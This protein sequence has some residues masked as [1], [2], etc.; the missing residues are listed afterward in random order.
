M[1]FFVHILMLPVKFKINTVF[2][3]Q[4][5]KAPE[6][7]RIKLRSKPAIN[8]NAKQIVNTEQKG[9]K[10]KPKDAKFLGKANQTF[11]R[12][13]VAKSNGSFKVAGMGIRKGA[14]IQKTSVKKGLE[15]QLEKARKVAKKKVKKTPVTM[16]R[17][18]INFQDLAKAQKHSMKEM[19]NPSRQ[20]AS[21]GLMNG[22]RGKTGL[23]KNND[24]IEDLPLGDMTNLNTIEYKYYGFYHRI[25]QKLEQYWGR[26]LQQKARAIYSTG[27]R[28]PASE[29]KITSLRITLD[30][31]GNIVDVW[32]KST[33]GIK[34]LDDAAIEAFNEAGPFPNPPKGMMKNGQ[35]MIEWGFVVK[36]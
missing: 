18:K 20:L 2:D 13:T 15:K 35:A 31:M 16:K 34:E 1:S 12:Q 25:R 33:S 30:N 22:A 8:E 9:K 27:R 3:L 11:D 7:L 10:I 28:L 24:F 21:K 23:A 4:E 29:N 5:R 36:G 14:E 17:A 19:M 6:V 32:V 26:N